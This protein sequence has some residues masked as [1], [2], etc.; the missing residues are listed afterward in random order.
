MECLTQILKSLKMEKKY[1]IPRKKKKKIPVGMYC[2]TPTSGFKVLK[3]GRYGY[4]I[5]SCP[6]YKNDG[7][8]LCGKCYLLKSTVVDQVK[9]CGINYGK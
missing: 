9:D 2:Y 3:D 4:T 7:D 1:K 6:F 5:K 8:G